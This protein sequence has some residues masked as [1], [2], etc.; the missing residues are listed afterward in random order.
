[1]V[2]DISAT[3]TPQP[4]GNFMKKNKRPYAKKEIEEEDISKYILGMIE[5]RK[6]KKYG[7]LL[8]IGYYF[9]CTCG[10]MH[11]SKN[12]KPS[13]QTIRFGDAFGGIARLSFHCENKKCKKRWHINFEIEKNK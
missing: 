8:S 5:K 6:Y 9:K 4:I 7:Q 13:K 2:K 1:M 10:Q 12:I 11:H 3:F